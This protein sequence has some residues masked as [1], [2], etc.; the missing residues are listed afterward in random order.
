M[1]DVFGRM[2]MGYF[3]LLCREMEK[4]DIRHHYP[5]ASIQAT[6]CNINKSEDTEKIFTA[7]DFIP[8]WVMKEER[9]E[10]TREE[11]SALFGAVKANA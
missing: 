10:A 9:R 7:W 1:P 5:A 4:Q 2:S 11:L 8:G 6:L 3:V